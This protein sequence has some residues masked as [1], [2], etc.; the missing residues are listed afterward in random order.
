M[1]EPFPGSGAQY[2]EWRCDRSGLDFSTWNSNLDQS[3]ELRVLVDRSVLEVFVDDGVKVCT[4]SFFMQNGP[5][6]EMQWLAE[7]SP[8]KWKT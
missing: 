2:S 1:S 5:P 6:T 7:N 8:V 4:S 3:I